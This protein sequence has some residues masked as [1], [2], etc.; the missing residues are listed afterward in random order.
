MC[1]NGKSVRH[2]ETHRFDLDEKQ[3]LQASEISVVQLSPIVKREYRDTRPECSL[4]T[5]G[6][7]RQHSAHERD[8]HRP[9]RGAS[10]RTHADNRCRAFNKPPDW[11]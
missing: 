4:L 7:G 11:K 3:L 6:K 9:T 8:E 2:C 1:Q 5:L 10:T